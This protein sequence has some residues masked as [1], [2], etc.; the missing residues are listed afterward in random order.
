[1]DL[2]LNDQDLAFQDEV[3]D[4]LERELPAELSAK[5]K[6]GGHLEKEDFYRWQR[7]LYDRG[8]IAP[9]WPAEYGG[10]GWT[11]T[12]RY[13]FERICADAWAPTVVPF[14]LRM[15]GPVIYTF[16][17][18]EQKARHLPGHPERRSVVVPGL[19]RARCRLRPGQPED[20]RRA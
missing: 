8:W 14:G 19:F 6:R 9:A 7:I 12:Q 3:R 4:F 10:T 16:G 15:V 20:P 1:M 13:I 2:Q 5:V 18:E 11:P 17:N